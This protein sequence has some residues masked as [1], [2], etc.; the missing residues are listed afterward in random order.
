LFQSLNILTLATGKKLFVDM[1]VNLSR[2]F[3]LWNKGSG[4]NFYIATDLE[5]FIPAD[6]KAF[7]KIITLQPNEL[8][9]GFSAKLHLDKLAPEGQT[10]FIDSDCLVYGDLLPVFEK[11]KGHR[12]SVVGN[13]IATGE[14]FG[15]VDTICK[16]Y[17]IPYLPKFNGGIYYLENGPIAKQVYAAAREL[18]TQYD[19][20]GFVRLRGRPNDEVLMAL[21]M[22]LHQQTPI[23]D[24]STIM[25]DPQSCPLPYAT[26]VIAGTNLLV[27][28]PAP[29]PLHQNWYPFN[30]VSSLVI[31][32]LGHHSADYQY[33]KDVYRLKKMAAGKLNFMADVNAL[34][35]IELKS[36]AVFYLKNKFRSIYHFLFGVRRINTTDRI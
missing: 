28:P 15:D 33:K 21:A 12:V 17:Q 34:I 7:T 29:H 10:L 2:S 22:Q 26:D 5:E 20:I 16:K 32:F 24:D 23:A 6:V 1:A 11:F 25:S 30:K 13:Y 18:E 36:K 31:H 19:E 9:I 14:W 8:G 27:N 4:I 35:V 3:N